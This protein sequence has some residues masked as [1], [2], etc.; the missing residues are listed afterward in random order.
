MLRFAGLLVLASLAYASDVI[1][2]DDSTFASDI[3]KHELILVEFFAPW[4]GHCK[5]LAPHYEM[6]AT[7]LKNDDPPV[8]LAKVDCTAN[9]ETCSKFGVSG[10]PTLKV[11]RNGEVAKDYD[12]GR[13]ESGIVQYLRKEAGPSYKELADVAAAEKYLG[14]AE[15]ALVGFFKDTKDLEAFKKAAG[16][17]NEKVRFAFTSDQAVMDKYGYSDEIVLLQPKVFHS[18]FEESTTKFEK[19][20]TTDNLRNFLDMNLLGLCGYRTKGN[21]D[22][23]TR[24][25]LVV[26]YY[27]VDYKKNVK[28]TNYWR[29]RVMKVGKQIKESDKEV[30]FAVS[31]AEEFGTELQEFGMNADKSTVQVNARDSRDRKFVMTEEFSMDT[32]KQFVNDFLDDKLEPYMKSEAVPSDNSGPVKVLVAK[33]FDEIVSDDKD[34]LVE[35]YAPWCGHCKSLE[36]KYNELGEKVKDISSVVIAK[37]DATANDVPSQYEVR[38]FPTIYFKPKGSQPRK[39]EGGREVDD[40]MKYLASNADSKDEVNAAMGGEKKKKKKKTE[41]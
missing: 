9:T 32:F 31:N 14:K 41:L 7:T 30:Y 24:K 27:D 12:G 16:V 5:N 38:G 10:Y 40:F 39:Y 36:P 2:Y 29:N 1:E 28:G 11:F 25:P 15:Y 17:L 4:C 35:F 6:A 37:M 22:S 3:G 20:V 21:A 33:N 23:F 8:A 18:K 19:S 26:A 13:D 34:V